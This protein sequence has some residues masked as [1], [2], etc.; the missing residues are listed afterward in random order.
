LI[1]HKVSILYIHPNK[2]ELQGETLLHHNAVFGVLQEYVRSGALERL[3]IIQNDKIEEMLEDLTVIGYYSKINNFLVSSLHMINVFSNTDSEF[4]TFRDLDP[5]AR[6][7]TFGIVE[8]DSVE[9]KLFFDLK[10]SREKRYYFGINRA[11][12]ETDVTILKKI[13]ENLKKKLDGMTKMSYGIYSTSYESN[14]GYCMV[15]S[16]LIQ[17][18]GEKS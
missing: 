10:M 18:E 16:S 5:A 1:K 9:E 17:T 12:L 15:C 3:Y 14:Y 2:E 11:A 7:A 8:P 4:D 13:K 6:I